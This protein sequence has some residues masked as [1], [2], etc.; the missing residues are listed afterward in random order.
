MAQAR[1]KKDKRY[2]ERGKPKAYCSR[3]DA[4]REG[5]RCNH[6]RRLGLLIYWTLPFVGLSSCLHP[7]PFCLRLGGCALSP[8]V[9]APRVYMQWQR[10]QAS[11]QAKKQ[12]EGK[13]AKRQ[14]IKRS[15]IG[16]T[17]MLS[18]K[19]GCPRRTN[20][21]LDWVSIVPWDSSMDDTCAIKQNY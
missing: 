13:H 7:C 16:Q 11:R 15:R 9:H 1:C 17:N 20:V 4:R 19:R 10:K 18:N 6:S 14:A 2:K 5:E 8:S 21:G 3:E 12:P